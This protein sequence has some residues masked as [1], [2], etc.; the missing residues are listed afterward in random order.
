VAT[1]TD[2]SDETGR[3]GDDPDGLTAAAQ[4]VEHLYQRARAGEALAADRLRSL[5]Q[6]NQFARQLLSSVKKA[7]KDGVRIELVYERARAG[8]RAAKEELRALASANDHAKQLLVALDGKAGRAADRARVE[9]LYLSA[10]SGDEAAL[11]GLVAL[12]ENN[13][14]ARHMVEFLAGRRRR[15]ENRRA[16][17]LLMRARRGEKD[18]ALELQELAEGNSHAATL[19]VQLNSIRGPR[20]ADTARVEDTYLRAIQGD[21]SA[22]S[23]LHHL[24]EK[25]S[26]ARHLI[27]LL[28]DVDKD[29]AQIAEMLFIRARGGDALALGE[30]RDLAEFNAHAK[31]L[32]RAIHSESGRGRWEANRQ[33]ESLS[34]R[35]HEGDKQAALELHELAKSNSHAKH[36]SSVLSSSASTR[37]VGRVKDQRPH[38]SPIS[39]TDYMDMPIEELRDLAAHDS[40]ALE[41]LAV[42]LREKIRDPDDDAIRELRSLARVN[43]HA[44]VQLAK[45]EVALADRPGLTERV[46][47]FAVGSSISVAGTSLRVQR[48]LREAPLATTYHVSDERGF[49]LALKSFPISQVSDW[50]E[51]DAY[52]RLSHRNVASLS[53]VDVDT[54]SL[55]MC[56]DYCTRGTVKDWIATSRSTAPIG[57]S[58]LEPA[59]S[60]VRQTALG[61]AHA[62]DSG[63]LHGDVKPSNLGFFGGSEGQALLIKL[64]DFGASRQAGVGAAGRIVVGTPLYCAPEQAVGGLVEA[65]DVYS[66]GCVFYE[67]LTGHPP[68]PPSKDVRGLLDLHRFGLPERIGHGHVSEMVEG[69]VGRMLAKDPADRPSAH[70]VERTL[71]GH[72]ADQTGLGVWDWRLDGLAMFES[73]LKSE[74][75]GMTSERSSGFRG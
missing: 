18:A 27:S 9:S 11:A 52:S 63:V 23:G 29:Q 28:P 32:L 20:R 59:L 47:T 64:L 10:Q 72:D 22:V 38:D 40:G 16:E 43:L 35:A 39:R 58:L 4:V 15:D 19:L 44:K 67:L 48:I 37:R 61:L 57:H 65:S 7:Q 55:L 50:S 45:A 42:S 75:V 54:N 53:L 12:A 24:A 62:H 5:S 70:Q 60:V 2:S 13:S 3:L 8:D 17:S 25:S 74:S 56:V 73:W 14:Q 26:H 21:T 31:H 49:E 36:L 6:T 69:L 68:F 1:S 51:I 71:S 30:L 34:R 66:L 33:A 46:R 41:V